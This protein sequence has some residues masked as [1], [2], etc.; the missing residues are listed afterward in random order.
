MKVPLPQD[1]KGNRT[2][3]LKEQASAENKWFA[4]PIV[5]ALGERTKNLKETGHLRAPDSYVVREDQRD[6]S[7][8]FTQMA[9]VLAGE[10]KAIRKGVVVIECAHTFSGTEPKAKESLTESIDG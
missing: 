7:V 10:R 5:Y 1:T 2:E 8:P 6:D 3:S 9:M 4:I